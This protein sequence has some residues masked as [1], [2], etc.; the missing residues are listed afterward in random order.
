MILL[1]FLENK[2]IRL[3]K[4]IILNG[5]EITIGSKI[6]YIDD[7]KLYENCSEI[8]LPKLGH[9]YT[10]RGFSYK[11]FY[12]EEIINDDI[13]WI[14]KNGKV[15]SIS[16][17]GFGSWRFEPYIPLQ[18]KATINCSFEKIVEERLE[19]LKPIVVT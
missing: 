14:D 19:I 2:K 3:V 16:E 9:I 10:V 11:G 18:K 12:L 6:K 5:V 8:I 15:D 4:A 1:L 17:P 13:Q 7:R